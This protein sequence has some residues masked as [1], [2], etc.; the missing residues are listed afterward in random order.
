MPKVPMPGHIRRVMAAIA[1]VLAVV[2]TVTAL[3]IL[4]WE[5]TISDWR[6]SVVAEGEAAKSGAV[7]FVFAQERPLIRLCEPRRSAG[8]GRVAAPPGPA[9]R[10]PRRRLPLS[11]APGPC[12]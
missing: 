12:R 3:T 5:N 4:G 1:L 6:S 2:A 11:A 9:G 8:P 10:L 7:S